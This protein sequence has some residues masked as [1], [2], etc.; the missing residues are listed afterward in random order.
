MIRLDQL[1]ETFVSN[2][3]SIYRDK[4]K[5]WSKDLPKILQDL[6]ERWNFRLI[7]PQENLS[8]NFVGL[9]ELLSRGQKLMLKVS[10]EAERL[11]S[12]VEALKCFYSD[13]PQVYK[14]DRGNAFLME[15]LSPAVTLKDLVRD[16]KDDEATRILA[17]K[18]VKLHQNQK[19]SNYPFKHLRSLAPSFDI[20]SG[21]MPQRMLSKAKSIFLDLT[22]QQP[23]D[24]I[25]HAD[26]HHENILSHG[27]A[28]I[29]IDP[30]GYIGDPIA[31]TAAMI[32][33]PYDAFPKDIALERVI[34]RRLKIM[35]E[36]LAF[37]FERMQAWAFCIT[38]LSEAASVEDFGP[39]HKIDYEFLRILE[40]PK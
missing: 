28:W 16:G 37:D 2:I 3:R 32:R 35:Q 4:G 29:V 7:A 39:E 22:K 40:P 17:Q 31:E 10:P 13:V 23:E 20:L 26:L 12:E 15:L 1:N 21:L 14:H 25:L 24:L 30:H 9:V 6:S 34:D 19:P 27:S 38:V 5:E 11:N 18:I 8:Y 33:N 36:E